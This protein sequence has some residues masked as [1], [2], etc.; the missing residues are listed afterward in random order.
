MSGMQSDFDEERIGGI[1]NRWSF[2]RWSATMLLDAGS[3]RTSILWCF[4]ASFKMQL[5]IASLQKLDSRANFADNSPCTC[6]S[7]QAWLESP[8]ASVRHVVTTFQ[9]FNADLLLEAMA[10][11]AHRLKSAV[12]ILSAFIIALTSACFHPE[13]KLGH[14][15]EPVP[16]DVTQAATIGVDMATSFFERRLLYANR[17]LYPGPSLCASI[18]CQEHQDVH[19]RAHQPCVTPPRDTYLYALA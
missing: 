1:R 2:E 9:S 12:C 3:E 5:Q 15:K 18:R 8:L 16:P 6:D 17:A 4:D 14:P 13:Q 10:P 19:D 7:L 11:N